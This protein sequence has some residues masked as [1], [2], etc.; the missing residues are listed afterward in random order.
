M[1]VTGFR[2][3]SENYIDI[4]ILADSEVSSANTS[5]PIEN[6]YNFQRRSKVWR[7]NGY[8]NITLANNRLIFRESTGVDLTA[9][10]NTGEYST[11]A[12][13]MAEIK[14]AMESVGDSTYTIT[15]NNLRFQFVSNGVGGDS[16][17]NLIYSGSTIASEI[18]LTADKTGSLT[19]IVDLIRIHGQEGEY[20]LW[21]MGVST[22]PDAFIAV[23]QR[24]SSIKIS[25]TA[26]V[27]LEGNETRNFS[28]PSFTTTLTHDDEV[29]SHITD[30]GIASVGYRYWRMYFDDPKNPN[31]YIQLGAVF[32][33]NFLSPSRGRAQF[34]LIQRYLDRTQTLFSDGGQSF[35]DIKQKS[36]Y[37]DVKLF[38]L[39]K[40]DI[41]EWDMFFY[42]FGTGKPFFVSLD[43]NEV[44]SSNKNRRIILCKLDS[45]PGWSLSSPD[46]FSL[47]FTLREEL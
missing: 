35:S 31:G 44:Y 18:G 15:Q 26:T 3:F 8:W 19:L 21:D 16:I 25:P 10:L 39:Q 9:V 20:I 11:T 30:S 29:F 17:F 45:N 22:N 40:A 2:I 14:R 47:T 42:S 23:D 43:T 13:L 33:G 32:L 24:N 36:Q 27:K 37:Y 12:S 1:S 46:T 38:G 6:I 4:D 28:S 5:Y 7:S 34:P 41:E